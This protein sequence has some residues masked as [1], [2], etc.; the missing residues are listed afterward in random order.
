MCPKEMNM[1]FHHKA[2]D[3]AFPMWSGSALLFGSRS[4]QTSASSHLP[5]GA[6]HFRMEEELLF[7]EAKRKDTALAIRESQAKTQVLLWE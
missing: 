2:G 4:Y 6:L 7:G 3:V 5:Q 1:F